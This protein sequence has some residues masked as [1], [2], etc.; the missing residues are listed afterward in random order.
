MTSDAPRRDPDGPQAP[1]AGAPPSFAPRSPGSRERAAGARREDARARR[2]A[3]PHAPTAGAA[4]GRGL[5]RLLPSSPRS[6]ASIL[7]VTLASGLLFT[8]SAETNRSA[9]EAGIAEPGLVSLVRSAQDEVDGLAAQVASL[10]DELA[11]YADDSAQGQGPALEPAALAESPVTGPGVTITLTDA[12]TQTIPEGATA[13]DLVIH[14]QDIEDVMNALWSSGAEAM[15]VQGVRVTSRTVVRCIGN[16]IL[17]DG[18]S[19]SPPYVVSA[20]GD[21]EDLESGVEADPRILNYKAYVALYGLGWDMTSEDELEFPA[22]N[23]KTTISYA[24]AVD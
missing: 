11:S 15:T 13:N 22:A 7:V 17:V 9:V 10:T 20:I 4:P 6:A 8:I 12:P 24:K 19:Y 16:V 21:P 3:R 18:R 14:Q 1:G 5:A 2:R 23:A